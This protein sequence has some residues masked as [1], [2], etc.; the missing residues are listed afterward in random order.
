MADVVTRLDG[1]PRD[2]GTSTAYQSCP[3]AHFPTKTSMKLTGASSVDHAK[4]TQDGAW[5]RCRGIHE[6]SNVAAALDRLQ[7]A[8]F[9]I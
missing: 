4:Q 9:A 8:A 5:W 7:L 6:D 1:C 2:A 3:E